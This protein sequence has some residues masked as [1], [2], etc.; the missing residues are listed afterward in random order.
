[1]LM[2]RSRILMFQYLKKVVEFR[3]KKRKKKIQKK[4]EKRKELVYKFY[5]KRLVKEYIEKD[6]EFI[7]NNK[8]SKYLGVSNIRFGNRP[9]QYSK[10]NILGIDFYHTN[11]SVFKGF[12]LDISDD[13]VVCGNFETNKHTLQEQMDRLNFDGSGLPNMDH[14]DEFRS[15]IKNVIRKLQIKTLNTPTK[16]CMDYVKFDMNTKPGIRYE[17]FFKK[18]KKSECRGI[19]SVVANHRWDAID[20]STKKGEMIKR[21]DISP[22]IYTIGARNKREDKPIDGEL[23]KSR[24]VHMPEF[25]A[26]L[27]CG[28]FSDVITEH[29]KNSGKGPLYIGNSI[30]KY[31]RLQKDIESSICSVEGDWRRFDSSLMPFLLVSAISILRCYFAEGLYVDNHFLA[32]IDSIVIKDY[33]FRGGRTYRILSGLPSGSKL[34]SLLGSVINALMLNYTFQDINTKKLSFAFGGDDFVVFIKEAVKDLEKFEEKVK[35]RCDFLDLKLKIFKFKNHNNADIRNFPVFYK[36]TVFRGR[37]FVPTEHALERA[38][39][40]WNKKYEKKGEIIKFVWDV[41]EGFGPPSTNYIMVYSYLKT[42]YKRVYNID[43]SLD[44]II[45]YHMS[46]ST[47]IFLLR[48]L[49]Y[50]RKLEEKDWCLQYV[51]VETMR[52]KSFLKKVF[53]I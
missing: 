8:S 31:E 53:Y 47:N 17:H 46:V 27:Q 22:S 49:V 18:N 24:A 13:V 11:E 12:D 51:N 7:T 50:T 19:A 43:K 25:H 28:C 32:I 29:I 21:R 16:G 33:I 41:L 34:T 36:Y 48:E 37:P 30:V 39:S 38:F 40:P 6:S 26:E 5:N 35:E 3:K 9:Q 42:L 23:A 20:N 44:E 4:R 15:V 52:N 10:P 1:M 2:I 45:D 14:Y